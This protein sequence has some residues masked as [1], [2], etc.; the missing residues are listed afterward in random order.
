MI[1]RAAL[2]WLMLAGAVGAQGADDAAR[3][4]A[5]ALEAAQLQLDRAVT[6]RDRVKAL[7]ETIRAFEAGLRSMRAGLR[8]AVIREAELTKRL[9]AQEAEVSRLLGAL[10]SIGGAAAPEAMLHPTGPVGTARAGMML[11]D[12]TPALA[13]EAA[14]LRADL[15]EVA[16]LRAL[17][18]SALGNLET[19]LEGVR[20]AR[21]ALT[22]AMAARTDLP[23]RFTE[24]PTQTAVLIAATETL[25]GFA[26]GL[27]SLADGQ[28]AGEMPS[29]E[30][31]KGALR[32]PV[33]GRI[34]RRA[35]EADAAGVTRP[36]VIMATEPGALVTSPVS[37][38]IRYR[39]PLLDY[40]LVSILEPQPDLLLVLAGLGTVYGEIGEVLPGGAP[41]GLM[42]G[43][44]Q[45]AG[46]LLSQS[47][48]RAGNRASET[49]YIEVRQQDEA[50]DPLTWFRA[51]KG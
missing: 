22:E 39:G 15:E 48:E 43:A 25:A 3:K 30:A 26:T 49:L 7:T 50:V 27:S 16:T 10:I 11:A 20:A 13:E 40:G 46:D 2:I 37:A 21:S 14:R 32:L 35:G 4:A 12:V 47:G 42:G 23:R 28:I 36:G 31:L 18:Q 38:T 29:I 33:D 44:E 51:D 6:A 1:L 19:G 45:E 8:V 41:V 34:L 5:E 24:D 17:Q 9:E